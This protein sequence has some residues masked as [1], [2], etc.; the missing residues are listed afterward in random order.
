MQSDST[1]RKRS[2]SN[3][4]VLCEVITLR[5]FVEGVTEELQRQVLIKDN[6]VWIS[7][8]LV[9]RCAQLHPV[10]VASRRLLQ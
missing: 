4:S 8:I 10:Q 6:L 1:V 3:C 2:T 5:M 9:H 7:L